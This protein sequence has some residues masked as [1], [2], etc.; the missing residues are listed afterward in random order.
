MSGSVINMVCFE[1]FVVSG[2]FWTDTVQSIAC[3]EKKEKN[4]ARVWP[5]WKQ[6]NLLHNGGFFSSERAT[7]SVYLQTP[8]EVVNKNRV[9]HT[10][11]SNESGS[12]HVQRRNKRRKRITKHDSELQSK[13]QHIQFV[14]YIRKPKS[15]RCSMTPGIKRLISLR[16][17]R[18]RMGFSVLSCNQL[19]NISGY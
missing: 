19:A 14:W 1:R 3:Y 7:I 17:K 6:W 16:T 5:L 9:A 18:C 8:N 13:V 15:E 11:C 2:L 10:R 4:D 12:L